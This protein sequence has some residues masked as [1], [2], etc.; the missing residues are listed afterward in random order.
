MC[1][2]KTPEKIAN[3]AALSQEA[4]QFELNWQ[5][6]FVSNLSGMNNALPSSQLAESAPQRM[7]ESIKLGALDNVIAFDLQGDAVDLTQ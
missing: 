7:V 5:V 1:V 6:V 4:K 2:D 3:F